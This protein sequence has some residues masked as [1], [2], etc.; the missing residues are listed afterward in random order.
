MDK[1]FERCTING[2]ML[3]NKIVRSAT[4]EGMAADDRIRCDNRSWSFFNWVDP[5][6]I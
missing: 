3:A 5:A 4:W 6:L 1:P 2:M